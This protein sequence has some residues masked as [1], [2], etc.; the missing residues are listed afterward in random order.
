ME[1]IFLSSCS[2]MIGQAGW[3]CFFDF[4]SAKPA[5]VSLKCVPALISAMYFFVLIYLPF[6]PFA[7]NLY[8]FPGDFKMKI[9]PITRQSHY[10][11]QN[12]HPIT[13]M[14]YILL[15]PFWEH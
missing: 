5:C 12:L 14:E 10:R 1:S 4:S 15:T 13:I 8:P 3:C 2:N 9:L 11:F 7:K 6:L